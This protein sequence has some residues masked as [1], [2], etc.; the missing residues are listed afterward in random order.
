VFYT[1]GISEA[2]NLADEEWGEE[3]LMDAIREGRGAPARELLETLFAAATAFAG[4]APQHDD[5]TLVVL[6]AFAPA[7]ASV[8]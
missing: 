8:G 7:G 2:M 1:D 6:R 3:R 5:M 4:T